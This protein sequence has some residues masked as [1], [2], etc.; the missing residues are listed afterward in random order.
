MIHLLTF[1]R[2]PDFRDFLVEERLALGDLD[3]DADRAFLAIVIFIGTEKKF[4]F[5]FC[6]IFH[7]LHFRICSFLLLSKTIQSTYDSSAVP[8]FAPFRFELVV[9]REWDLIQG[10]PPS[11]TS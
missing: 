11:P 5:F 6:K 2:D 3:R 9:D 1:F 8:I 4:D 10:T 7:W